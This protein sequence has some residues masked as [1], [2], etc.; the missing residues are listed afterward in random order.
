MLERLQP[1]LP[2]VRAPA[3]ASLVLSL[4]K[5][6]LNPDALVPGITDSLGQRFMVDMD[7]ASGHDLASVLMACAKLQLSPCEGALRKVILARM[8]VADS[9]SL[10]SQQVANRLHSMAMTT[11]ATSP[12]QL[13]DSLCKRFGVLLKSCQAD[14]LPSVQSIATTISALNKLRFAPA[15]ELAMSMVGRMVSL[16]H[17]SEQQPAPQLVSS[18]LFACAELNVLVRQT[19]ADSLVSMLLNSNG[20]RVAQQVNPCTA[21]LGCLHNQTLDKMIH[22]I[23]SE[24]SMPSSLSDIDLYQLYQALDWL[25]PV[26]SADAQLVDAWVRLKA[27]IGKLGPRPVPSSA[28][29]VEAELVCAALTQLRLRFT[30]QTVIN[31][32]WVAAILE[33][34][35]SGLSIVLGFKACQ[36]IRH[37]PVR[38]HWLLSPLL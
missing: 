4:A 15:N 5:L 33:P 26:A 16:C 7:A 1:L 14:E 17:T 32:Y 24:I 12:I 2:A 25:Q 35:H 9:S 34:S 38:Y 27:K 20:H 11:A 31:N 10:G 21:M 6:R 19:D 8:A 29:Y 13:I 3:A 22:Q 30:A 36:F 37:K 18:F 28:P 23:S